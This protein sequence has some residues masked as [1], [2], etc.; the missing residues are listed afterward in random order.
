[1]KKFKDLREQS[2]TGLMSLSTPSQVPDK[3]ALD[4]G[5]QLM[6]RIPKKDPPPPPVTW[7]AVRTM[8]NKPTAGDFPDYEELLRQ[9]VNKDKGG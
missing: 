7:K 8:S 4:P 6:A 1:M 5:E 9:K 2:K 3:Y